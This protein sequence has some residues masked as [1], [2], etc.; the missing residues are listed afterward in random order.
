M[1]KLREARYCNLKLLLVFF[2][3]YG[4]L[5][6]PGI[7]NNDRWMCQYRW[8]Y[9][10][11]MPLFAFLSGLFLSNRRGCEAQAKKALPL[12][13]LLQ[14][15]AVILGKGGVDPLTP[16]WHLWYLLSLSCWTALAW[17]WFRFAKGRGKFAILLL[18]LCAGCCAGCSRAI[19]RVCSLSRTIVFFPYFWMGVICP[20]N[21]P[22]RKL[23]AAAGVGLGICL[24]LAFTAGRK[25]PTTFLYQADPFGTIEGGIWLRLLCYLLG[26]L[27]GLFLLAWIPARRFT[28]TKVGAN[29]MAPYLLHA[30]FVQALWTWN[31]SSWVYALAAALFLYLVFKLLQWHGAIYGIVSPERRDKRWQHSKKCTNNTENGCM[32]SCC[33]SPEVR[34]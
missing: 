20:K 9:F 23:R 28:F 13:L 33:P 34:T 19:G 30:P 11:H 17:L 32:A 5:L 27:L 16:Y 6:E 7:W 22:W 15:G 8:I 29:T 18:A 1:V 24:I 2:V 26:T 31:C 4:H 14:T 25:I 21:F 12:Y 3:I 10:V